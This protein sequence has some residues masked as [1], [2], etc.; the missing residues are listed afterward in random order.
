[1]NRIKSFY[2]FMIIY[3][4]IL[5]GSVLG[6]Y[7]VS[8]NKGIVST[9]EKMAL[10]M[11]K[12]AFMQNRTEPIILCS[13][14]RHYEN[15]SVF[16]VSVWYGKIFNYPE[17]DF[18]IAY[19]HDYIVDIKTGQ[20]EGGPTIDS[21]EGFVIKFIGKEPITSKDKANQTYFLLINRSPSRDYW[22]LS[23]EDDL[24]SL[25]VSEMDD[26]YRVTGT[27]KNYA[28]NCGDAKIEIVYNIF[29]NGTATLESVKTICPHLDGGEDTDQ[30]FP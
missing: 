16:F 27:F 22:I 29:K 25:E 21:P 1:M 12:Q 2:S 7:F 8:V 28:I 24:L 14:F 30:L 5:T 15:T 26:H 19:R 17:G 23:V 18:L 4:L 10:E 11:A 3:I 9:E 13:I 20:I 6:V